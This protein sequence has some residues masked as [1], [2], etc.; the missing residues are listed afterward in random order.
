MPASYHDDPQ[1][2]GFR[3]VLNA[4]DFA[5]RKHAGQ[6]RKGALAEPYINHLIEVAQLVANAIAGPDPNLLAAALLHDTVEDTKTTAEELIE[7][8]GP[9]VAALVCELT[10]DKSLPKSERKRRQVEHA[11]E[12][13]VR[14]Q[15]LKLADKISNLRGILHSPPAD[16]DLNLKREY[17]LWGKD[18]VHGMTSPNPVLEKEFDSTLQK[19]EQ[20]LG[21]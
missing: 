16:W 12:L 5:A 13:S 10:D 15:I 7:A 4:A 9:D 20:M 21:K 14:A 1:L 2:A 6:K 3:I 11:P 17:V 18:V 8:F 19:L